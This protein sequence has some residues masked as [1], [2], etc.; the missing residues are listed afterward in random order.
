MNTHT[1]K[2]P[3]KTQSEFDAETRKRG[4]PRHPKL[5]LDPQFGR[6]V[7]TT[8]S[9]TGARPVLQIELNPDADNGWFQKKINEKWNDMYAL[10]Q[11]A[12][13]PKNCLPCG[14]LATNDGSMADGLRLALGYT[15]PTQSERVKYW[16]SSSGERK[17]AR[18]KGEAQV[19]APNNLLEK[20]VSNTVLAEVTAMP[21]PNNPNSMVFIARDPVA[22]R[23]M[24]SV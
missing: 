8:N 7:T 2:K 10:T 14:I 6:I 13:G 15:L 5:S 4:G 24:P 23:D 21:D 17:A 22:P 20:V 16:N 18:E 3:T 19:P 9:L 12:G 1:Q 11:A